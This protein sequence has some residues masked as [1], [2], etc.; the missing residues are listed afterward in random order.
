MMTTI[1]KWLFCG[2]V[3]VPL[4]LL[5]SLPGANNG[6]S[7]HQIANGDGNNSK[8]EPNGA[9]SGSAA[10]VSVPMNDHLAVVVEIARKAEAK[11]RRGLQ[12]RVTVEFDD[13][14][15]DEAM[16][17]VANQAKLPLLINETSLGEEGIELDEPVSG[18]FQNLTAEQV[19]DRLLKPLDLTWIIE[20]EVLLITTFIDAEEKLVQQVY[21]VKRLRLRAI[22]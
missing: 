16:K 6:H 17:T 15:L 20:N 12:S 3:L 5:F 9:A 19:I 13:T 18:R 2:C 4:A 11:I 10:V 14:S 1:S 7:K 21:D 22:G 8:I